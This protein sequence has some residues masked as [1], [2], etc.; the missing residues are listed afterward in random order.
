MQTTIRIRIAIAALAGL[1]AAPM[2]SQEAVH[3]SIEVYAMGSYS[4]I[5]EVA[6]PYIFGTTQKMNAGGGFFGAGF[7]GRLG[8]VGLQ[9]EFLQSRMSGAAQIPCLN[10]G[11]LN[12]VVEKRTGRI[13]P[14]GIAGVGGAE[15]AGNSYLFL[16]AGAGVTVMLTHSLFI[17][18]QVRVQDW[19]RLGVLM[20]SHHTAVS[21]VVAIGYRFPA[22]Q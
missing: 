18:P 9:T 14:G 10:T 20:G 6:N 4:R 19:E 1:A 2:F 8:P 7:G 15:D 5:S 22:S 3:R 16:Q 12:I 13:R 21:A 11:A 17:R